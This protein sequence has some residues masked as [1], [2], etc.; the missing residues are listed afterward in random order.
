MEREDVFINLL[1]QI[2]TSLADIVN[3]LDDIHEELQ[4]IEKRV[5]LV[6]QVTE[7]KG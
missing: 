6:A 3:S 4:A 7:A 1:H 5:A 2:A